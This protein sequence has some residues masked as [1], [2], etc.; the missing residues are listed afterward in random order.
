[1]ALTGGAARTSYDWL[2]EGWNGTWTPARMKPDWAQPA[3]TRL[4]LHT[5]A[6]LGAKTGP[7][8]SLV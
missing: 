6:H 7:R 2:V 4:A 8:S 3:E 1:M 5:T